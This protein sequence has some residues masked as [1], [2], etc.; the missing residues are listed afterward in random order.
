MWFR[1]GKSCL[2]NLI[3]FYNKFT[4][5]VDEG[6]AGDVVLDFS[7]AL[8]TVPHSTLLDKVSSCGM[9]RFMARWVRNRLKGGAQRAVVKE[10]TSGW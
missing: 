1:Q 2:T 6:K 7:K 5:L 4:C 8:D 10:A 3:S 9:S